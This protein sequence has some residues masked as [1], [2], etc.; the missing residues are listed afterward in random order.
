MLLTKPTSNRSET[1][2]L[3][4]KT[5][6]KAQAARAQKI[7]SKLRTDGQS[8]AQIDIALDKEGLIPWKFDS[9]VLVP[10]ADDPG[11]IR[12]K[13]ECRIC[14]QDKFLIKLERSK[15]KV[16][17]Y[18][19]SGTF[20]MCDRRDTM[21]QVLPQIR[22]AREGKEL[23][24]RW[25]MEHR[26]KRGAS[27]SDKTLRDFIVDEWLP[28]KQNDNQISG[29]QYQTY[30]QD[31]L[32]YLVP[33][34]G[35]VELQHVSA[36][37]VQSYVTSLTEEKIRTHRLTGRKYSS[38]VGP[39]KVKGIFATLKT[40]LND[41]KRRYH[42]IA[43]NP[44]LRSEAV[45]QLPQYQSA[46]AVDADARM[47]RKA[48]QPKQLKAYIDAHMT[49]LFDERGQLRDGMYDELMKLAS[50]LIPLV[51]GLRPG[52]NCALQRNDID[53]QR[54]TL[55]VRKAITKRTRE[56]NRERMKN[57]GKPSVTFGLGPTKGR[58]RRTLT[59]HEPLP[60]VLRTLIDEQNRRG[61]K[62]TDGWL[63]PGSHGAF[64]VPGSGL[65]ERWKRHFVGAAK[66]VDSY[67]KGEV[68]LHYIAPYG[69]RHTSGTFMNAIGMDPADI[70]EALGHSKTTGTAMV[71]MHYLKKT[72]ERGVRRDRIMA[73][74]LKDVGMVA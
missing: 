22:N 14:G 17:S 5:I 10:H 34:I 3:R 1:M 39:R 41:A 8:A 71:V 74:G 21:D 24:S 54:S 13:G 44:I 6:T 46:D 48:W 72:V 26:E 31:C 52:E 70:A 63:S 18:T 40:I 57:A 29:P 53:W 51:L 73:E 33:D 36:E 59:L 56:S 15:G 20:C 69:I 65:Y 66:R 28:A 64:M 37:G 55:E 42:Y 45:I 61:E 7:S 67:T 43:V 23:L 11:Q 16:S 49:Y 47:D 50:F 4:P 25:D 58:S 38:K 12:W 68:Q 27:R 60:F 9:S 35:A 30:E 2:S 32:G 62:N 19:R